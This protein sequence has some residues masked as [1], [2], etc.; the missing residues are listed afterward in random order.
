MKFQRHLTVIFLSLFVSTVHAA[1]IKLSCKGLQG[2]RIDTD[3]NDP[4]KWSVG[5]DSYM[6]VEIRFTF[7]DEEA[8]E[9]LEQDG[10]KVEWGQTAPFSSNWTKTVFPV[11]LTSK[12]MSFIQPHDT[13]TRLYSLYYPSSLPSH[14]GVY[15]AY[16]E[17]Q[18]DL[19]RTGLPEI[20]QFQATCSVIE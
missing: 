10:L 16:T 8:G 2:S 9:S 18:T 14:K 12:W 5:P 19:M 3:W 13:V 7:P 6:N 4:T 17:H 20:K 15:L 1:Q 11:N